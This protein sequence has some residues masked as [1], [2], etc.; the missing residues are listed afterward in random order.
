M[1]IRRL[2]KWF[3]TVC[4]LRRVTRRRMSRERAAWEGRS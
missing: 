4:G 2:H 1:M 3:L